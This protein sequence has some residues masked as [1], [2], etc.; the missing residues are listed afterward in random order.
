VRK[1]ARALC[2]DPAGPR[3]EKFAD[4][5]DATAEAMEAVDRP[6]RKNQST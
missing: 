5:L 2:E 3:L 1:H 4:E 6:A